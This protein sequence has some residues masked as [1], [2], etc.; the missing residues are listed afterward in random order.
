MDTVI[1][2]VRERYLTT[3]MVSW[4]WLVIETAFHWHISKVFWSDQVWKVMW[5]LR[6][7]VSFRMEVLKVLILQKETATFHMRNHLNFIGIIRKLIVY[8]NVRQIMLGVNWIQNAPLGIFQV[9][10][11]CCDSNRAMEK[12]ALESKSRRGSGDSY[13]FSPVRMTKTSQKCF[14]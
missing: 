2:L 11:I 10:I 3:S 14:Q 12:V 9:C 13:E 1:K 6:L 5:L 7:Q 8:L 4:L